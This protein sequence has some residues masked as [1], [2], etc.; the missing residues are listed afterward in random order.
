MQEFF[1]ALFFHVK[2]IYYQELVLK[3]RENMSVSSSAPSAS[4]YI[5]HHLTHLSSKPQ[6]SIVDFTV[7][8]LDT[9]FWSISMG[10]VAC[11]V[12]FLIARKANSGVPGRLQSALEMLIEMVDNQAKEIIHGDRKFIAPLALTVFV[13]ISLMNALDFLPVDLISAILNVTGLNHY[14]HYQ[15][16]VPTADLNGTL[17]ISLGVLFL[18]FWYGFKVKGF[19]GFTKEIFSAPLGIWCAPFNFILNCVEYLAKF[20]SSGMR[21]FGNMY[22][23]ELIFL[24]IALLGSTWNFDASSSFFGFIGHII[25]GSAWSIFHILVI[26][27]QAFIFMMLTL[28]YLGQSHDAH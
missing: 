18:M 19:L 15:R 14:I 26:F 25:L 5:T 17:G 23:G 28:I 24:L 10:L 11:L 20:V 22:A 6:K 2:L 8:H 21:L 16:V 9:L 4:D 13:W 1:W 27:L 7:F 3:K 12:M